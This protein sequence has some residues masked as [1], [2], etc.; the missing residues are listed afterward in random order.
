M[1]YSSADLDTPSG[2]QA[3]SAYNPKDGVA[4]ASM[5]THSHKDPDSGS[6]R[7]FRSVGSIQSLRSVK[8]K[9]S[10]SRSATSLNNSLNKCPTANGYPPHHDPPPHAVHGEAA[11]IVKRQKQGSYYLNDSVDGYLG[12]AMHGDVSPPRTAMTAITT[13]TTPTRRRR[14]YTE[15]SNEPRTPRP[16]RPRTRSRSRSRAVSRE[17]I[18]KMDKSWASFDEYNWDTSVLVLDDPDEVFLDDDEDEDEDKDY[19][20]GDPEDS[21]DGTLDTLD[22]DSRLGLD[23][24]AGY[25]TEDSVDDNRLKY[26]LG[27]HDLSY[28][29]IPRRN[30][31]TGRL[32]M[33]G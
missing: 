15:G 18:S 33:R 8:S 3:W 12:D 27:E 20:S 7:K 25:T 22:M 11:D 23:D 2:G 21:R 19:L 13:T 26:L 29:F 31:R 9:T 32:I 6:F 5:R 4:L 30:L 17:S 24:T 28:L 16:L 14:C 1:S 10:F